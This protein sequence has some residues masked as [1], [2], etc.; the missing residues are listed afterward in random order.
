MNGFYRGAVGDWFQDAITAMFAEPA[1]PE[2]V[3]ET[4]EPTGRVNVYATAAEAD[5]ALVHR[6]SK[7]PCGCCDCP[8]CYD[9]TP[10]PDEPCACLPD[11]GID[12]SSE[13]A[14]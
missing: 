1:P 7:I 8:G 9:C 13:V 3:E 6:M 14:A 11:T 10:D 4:P 2:Q 5:S 12:F